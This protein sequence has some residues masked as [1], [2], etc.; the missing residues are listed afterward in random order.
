[1]LINAGNVHFTSRA[2]LLYYVLEK[3]DYEKYKVGVVCRGWDIIADRCEKISKDIS[4]LASPLNFN[5]TSAES[6]QH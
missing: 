1:M 3:I 2:Q 5:L 4:V 6:M